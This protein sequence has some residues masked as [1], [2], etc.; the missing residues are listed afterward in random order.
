MAPKSRAQNNN[1]T[2]ARSTQLE[3]I[4]TYSHNP[5][6]QSSLFSEVYLQ[7][8]VPTKY[9]DLWEKDEAGEFQEFCTQFVNLCT[10]LKDSDMDSW[11]E[12]NT[13]NRLIKPVLR[14]LGY[15]N[16]CSVNQES[17]AEDEPFTIREQ[18]EAKT[19]KPDLI[20]VNNPKEL[21]Y[22]ERK[23]GEEKLEEAR[24]TVLIPIEAKYWAR[25]DDIKQNQSEDTKRADKKDQADP[26]RSLD[27]DEQCLKYMEVLQKD[28]GILTDGK[29]WRL[30]NRELSSDSYRRNFQFNLGH[31]IKHVN[32][33]LDRDPRDYDVFKEQAKYF[34]Y[35]FSK[36]A[37][38]S[39]TNERR[40]LDDLLEYSKTYVSKV[41]E[42]LK[43]RFVKA[44]AHACNGFLRA[45]ESNTKKDRVN[46]SQVRNIAESHLFNIL[47]IKH[48]EARG[49]LPLK[50]SEFRQISISNVI[51]KLEHFN[52][53]KEEDGLN[54]PVLRRMFSKDFN[55][56]PQGTE[57]YERLLKLTKIVQSGTKSDFREFEIKGFR[58]TVFSKD[59]WAF[60]QEHKLTNS[61]MVNILFEL[62]Y[63]VSDLIG[64]RFQQIPYNFF[65]PRQL[66]SIYESFLEFRLDRAEQDMAFIRKQWV[67]AKLESEKIRALDVPKVRKGFLFFT[68]DNAERKVTGS[69][70]TP[71]FLVQ[72]IVREVLDS[73]LVGKSSKDITAIKV[74]DPAL[75]SGHFVGAALNY[76]ARAY[77]NALERET[78]DDLSL[79]LLEAKR[80]ILHNCIYGVDVNPRAVKLAKMS[81]WLESATA[82]VTL[83]DL[84]D[85]LF[86]ANS[87]MPIT[88][89]KRKLSLAHNSHAGSSFS[90]FHELLQEGCFNSKSDIEQL[91][92]EAPLDTA[93]LPKF[94][95]IIGN[96]PYVSFNLIPG[97][98]KQ[99]LKL[100]FPEVYNL[101]AD[102]YYY[103]FNLAGLLGKPQCSVGFLTMRN[104]VDAR[105]AEKVRN[106][107]NQNFQGSCIDF[108]GIPIFPDI[109]ADFAVTHLQR[110]S[111][112]L[113]FQIRKP[114]VPADKIT[115]D[116]ESNFKLAL[117]SLSSTRRKN[118]Q[119]AAVDDIE[120]VLP[121]SDLADCE[122]GV[123]SG[124][125]KVFI[126]S[127]EHEGL[128]MFLKEGFLFPCVRNKNLKDR[129][130]PAVFEK[131]MFYIDG[132]SHPKSD[133]ETY[134]YLKSNQ[135]KLDE[136]KRYGA[137]FHFT[138]LQ[139]P[140]DRNNVLA[141]PKIVVPY[142]S[143][144]NNFCL[145][146]VGAV[147]DTDVNY[148][149]LKSGVRNKSSYLALLAI[150]NSTQWEM[151]FRSFAKCASGQTYD[152]YANALKKIKVPK[153]VAWGEEVGL[154]SKKGLSEEAAAK[155]T[156]ALLGARICSE[157]MAKDS[158]LQRELDSTVEGLFFGGFSKKK[159]A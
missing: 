40:F 126:L 146:Q 55:Y 14:L 68:P 147:S 115:T 62:G 70:Y 39:E 119:K 111:S 117:S 56:D 44:M 80:I 88:V 1:Q 123:Q 155:Q 82:G 51:A 7:N 17:W 109:G 58:E 97:L 101:K 12:R 149:I 107:I 29:T 103:F 108:R 57:L 72:Y 54:L 142:K 48:C 36:S 6:W 121:L 18:G 2:E 25:I 158:D 99:S 85:Q 86:T 143:T 34:F 23:K 46:L 124:A 100:F 95:A 67:P 26:T 135:D 15:H 134:K 150:L 83:E 21:K 73:L 153:N 47:F 122:T 11:S 63:C 96:P 127:K 137:D 24:N 133:S 131:Y 38:Y 35:L 104:F 120:E 61:E 106:Y 98:I 89:A 42:D 92:K 3:L 75:G 5:F 110:G 74:C 132:T 93:Q 128:S 140:R 31:L 33:G 79:T 152:Y 32:A 151:H 129:K 84:S 30:Y 43:V 76:L 139:W 37:L 4:P 94:D 138:E 112:S 105:F 16:N 64:K 19:Y 136:R 148:I 65:S 9:Q 145:D 159:A 8:D 130:L 59:E 27:F 50:Q 53:E 157:G 77:L 125:V 20:I 13:I 156:L 66:G 81:L 90:S 28:Y 116:L 45:A 71:D 69:Y 78:N 49:V 60:V 91:E 114:N 41:E 113:G 10:E 52:P 154:S 87:L 141:N 144:I 22:I 118:E 102:Y